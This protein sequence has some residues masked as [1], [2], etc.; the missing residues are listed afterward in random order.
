MVERSSGKVKYNR[1]TIVFQA[2]YY[3]IDFMFL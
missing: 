2:R 1:A 3:S